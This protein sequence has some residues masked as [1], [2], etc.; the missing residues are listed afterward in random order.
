[1]G[2][3]KKHLDDRSAYAQRPRA[4][5]RQNVPY[6]PDQ[7]PPR[8]EDPLDLIM[9]DIRRIN[10]FAHQFAEFREISE[11]IRFP[12]LFMAMAVGIINNVKYIPKYIPK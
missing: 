1:M 3:P 5:Y 7:S 12:G 10:E 6:Y 8:K 4:Y 2:L 11:D 9:E